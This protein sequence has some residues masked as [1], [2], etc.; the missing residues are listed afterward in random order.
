MV[1]RALCATA[2]GFTLICFM[3]LNSCMCL[4]WCA[5]KGGETATVPWANINTQETLRGG[6]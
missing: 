3:Y 2:A 6:I 5:F 4:L 1:I